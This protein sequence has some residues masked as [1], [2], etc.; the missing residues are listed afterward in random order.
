MQTQLKEIEDASIGRIVEKRFVCDNKIRVV[1]ER[2][3]NKMKEFTGDRAFQKDS[4]ASSADRVEDGR[5]D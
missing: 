1:H 3:S 4:V 5:A 2:C